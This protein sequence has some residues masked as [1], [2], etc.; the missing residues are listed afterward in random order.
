MVLRPPSHPKILLTDLD[1]FGGNTEIRKKNTYQ[2][3]E[4]CVA[5]LQTCAV[6]LMILMRHS[7]CFLVFFAQQQLLIFLTCYCYY[8]LVFFFL[9][10]YYGLA[11]LFSSILHI[12]GWF[13][14]Q[15]LFS[16]LFFIDSAAHYYTYTFKRRTDKNTHTLSRARGRERRGTRETH[17]Y[18][19][20]TLLLLALYLLLLLMLLLFVCLLLLFEDLLLL[21]LLWFCCN[22]LL[23]LLLLFGFE[24]DLFIYF[25]NFVFLLPLCGEKLNVTVVVVALAMKHTHSRIFHVAAVWKIKTIRYFLFFFLTPFRISFYLFIIFSL[26]RHNRKNINTNFFFF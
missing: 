14:F 2:R 9:N 16:S 3:I 10:L 7:C 13:S 21:L 1:I 6:C 11:F 5:V 12:C 4:V 24:F 8:F 25:I 22:W 26:T 18:T 15:I 23:A 20:W 17:R 19:N